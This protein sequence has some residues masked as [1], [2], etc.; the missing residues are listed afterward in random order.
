VE[1][2][3]WHADSDRKSKNR[4]SQIVLVIFLFIT[5]LGGF[6]SITGNDVALGIFIAGGVGLAISAVWAF[7]N[8]DY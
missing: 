2:Q 8:W 4:G 3:E 7:K 1:E 6:L 5:L